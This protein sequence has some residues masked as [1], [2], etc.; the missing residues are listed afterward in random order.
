L[1][2]QFTEEIGIFGQQSI[3]VNSANETSNKHFFAKTASELSN[4]RKDPIV[5]SVSKL[6]QSPQA[7]NI[8]KT[9]SLPGMVSYDRLQA[10]MPGIIKFGA[11][12]IGR[13]SLGV[14][15]AVNFNGDGHTLLKI[16]NGDKFEAAGLI[17]NFAKKPFVNEF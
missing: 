10:L 2:V 11:A 5:N 13:E 6:L 7:R 4:A 8:S 3:E 16:S 17:S 9:L 15:D 14:E 12:A 1:S